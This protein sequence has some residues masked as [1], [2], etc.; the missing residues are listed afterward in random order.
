MMQVPYKGNIIT[1]I[2]QGT[3]VGFDIQTISRSSVMPREASV[4]KRRGTERKRSL[5][6]TTQ[7]ING[8]TE[9]L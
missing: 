8:G 5:L 7:V 3:E 4:S 6:K 2:L 1:W 9:V